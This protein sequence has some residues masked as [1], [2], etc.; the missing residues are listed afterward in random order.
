MH[1]TTWGWMIAV[2]LPTVGG[3]C[4]VAA[5]DQLFGFARGKD[6][7]AYIAHQVVTLVNGAWIL[8]VIRKSASIG[9]SGG[10]NG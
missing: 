4:I 2:L 5:V 1:K 10:E 3:A 6:D 8:S 9:K 7:L